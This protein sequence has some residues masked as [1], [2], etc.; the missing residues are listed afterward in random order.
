M[1]EVKGEDDEMQEE[2][3]P[4]F[5]I[6]LSY[7]AVLPARIMTDQLKM[8]LVTSVGETDLAVEF[9]TVLD[10]RPEILLQAKLQFAKTRLFNAIQD[11][12]KHNRKE[13]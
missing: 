10:P 6:L 7:Q 12:Q 9:E 4:V 2:A 5:D 3:E 13:R 1:E 11:L 8:Q